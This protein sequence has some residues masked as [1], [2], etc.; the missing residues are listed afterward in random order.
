M[1]QYLCLAYA[2]GQLHGIMLCYNAKYKGKKPSF[3]LNDYSTN[4][5]DLSYLQSYMSGESWIN[6]SNRLLKRKDSSAKQLLVSH[7]NEFITL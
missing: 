3:C 1:K 2:F 7:N 4:A 6:L 5:T